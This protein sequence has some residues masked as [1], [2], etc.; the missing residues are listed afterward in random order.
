MGPD[1]RRREDPMRSRLSDVSGSGRT[2]IMIGLALAFAT[3]AWF[4]TQ[5]FFEFTK[6]NADEIWILFV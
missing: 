3:G 5:G 1:H 2:W 4:E 6:N